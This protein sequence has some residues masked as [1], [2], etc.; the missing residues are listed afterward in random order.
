MQNFKTFFQ[1][2]KKYIKTCVIYFVIFLILMIA[3]THLTATE[4]TSK[5]TAD[6]VDFTVIDKDHTQAS[7][8]LIDYLSKK[9]HFVS[10]DSEDMDSIKDNMYFQMIQY[11][12]MIPEGYEEQ[13]KDGKYE[14]IITHSMRTD[15]AAGYFFNQDIDSYFQA[16]SLYH[17]AGTSL[18]NALNQT[19][20]V[21][22]EIQKNKVEV[23][24]FEK[25]N[26]GTNPS[27][28]YFQYFAYIL[29]A[30]MLESMAP[31]LSAFQKRDLAARISCSSMRPR[32]R[33]IGIGSGAIAFSVIL[34]VL[35]VFAG[36]IT[37]QYRMDTPQT[38]LY[39]AG[40]SFIYLLVIVTLTLCVASF[41]LG[42]HSLSLVS[43]VIGLGSSFLCG[44]FVPLWLLSDN[45]TQIARFLPTYWYI[46]NNN[47]L[48]GFNG[49]AFVL[50]NY[51]QNIGLQLLFA[52]TFLTVYFVIHIRRQL[53]L[54]DI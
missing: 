29:I 26:N 12:I 15:S 36:L 18:E 46:K 32:Q 4:K 23:L 3:M 53:K 28:Y 51:L 7:Q 48:A 42:G 45:V 16:L 44:V 10:F 54:S 43:N 17:T 19:E 52:V 38:I 39:M 5:F 1:I 24:T 35:I 20:E 11:V 22:T 13:L 31:I 6:T 33:S 21:L 8:A 2:S 25:S 47:M 37:G 49:E 30:F 9:H 40:N 27:G 34:W 50:G 41:H 14:D